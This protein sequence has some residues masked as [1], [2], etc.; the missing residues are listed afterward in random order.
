VA[1]FSGLQTTWYSAC[2]IVL[3]RMFSFFFAFTMVQILSIE[4]VIWITTYIIISCCNITT[5]QPCPDSRTHS[6]LLKCTF[7]P[8]AVC[9]SAYIVNAK[10]DQYSYLIHCSTQVCLWWYVD[11]YCALLLSLLQ[12]FWEQKINTSCLKNS[13]NFLSLSNFHRFW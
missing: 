4:I 8:H 11:E 7:L 13:H 12:V 6:W 10:I 9:S 1:F 2:G 5:P 3:A